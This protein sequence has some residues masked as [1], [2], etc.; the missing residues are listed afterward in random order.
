MTLTKNNLRA[1]ESAAYRKLIAAIDEADA[2]PSR[3]LASV[4]ESKPF[5]LFMAGWIGVE[6]TSLYVTFQS[7]WTTAGLEF[8]HD[9]VGASAPPIFSCSPVATGKAGFCETHR[10][11]EVSAERWRTV[12]RQSL[13]GGLKGRDTSAA[14]CARH[15]LGSE[16]G[17][18]RH[19]LLHFA[20]ILGYSF[21]YHLLENGW[22]ATE[23]TVARG[24]ALAAWGTLCRTHAKRSGAAA[25]VLAKELLQVLRDWY[26]RTP[27]QDVAYSRDFLGSS[28]IYVIYRL[29]EPLKA[30]LEGCVQ[31]PTDEAVGSFVTNWATAL[32]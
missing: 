14:L 3:R 7:T 2:D 28:Q 23:S 19:L 17:K 31:T 27:A 22:S 29:G 11:D 32:M 5:E 18:P 26:E 30:E 15:L 4:L 21:V 8:L 13:E 10:L 20:E 24:H 12:Q 1:A 16:P 25:D 6:A 9:A